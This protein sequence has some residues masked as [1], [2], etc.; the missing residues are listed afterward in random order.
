M[1]IVILTFNVFTIPAM[2]LTHN[3]TLSDIPNNGPTGLIGTRPNFD[4]LYSHKDEQTEENDQDK[5]NE[6][7]DPYEEALK[8]VREWQE[9]SVQVTTLEE[10]SYKRLSIGGCDYLSFGVQYSCSV[11]PRACR[12]S[13][14]GGH[15]HPRAC[16]AEQNGKIRRI[17]YVKIKNRRVSG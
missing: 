3:E 15:F 11:H 12:I 4:T 14:A 13:A 10:N 1:I 8:K 16:T 9:T 5:Q 6:E 17:H 2:A 7:I